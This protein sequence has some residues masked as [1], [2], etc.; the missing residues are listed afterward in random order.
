MFFFFNLLNSIKF[1]EFDHC[2]DTFRSNRLANKII[3]VFPKFKYKF[4]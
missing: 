3:K 4:L 1:P 2:F